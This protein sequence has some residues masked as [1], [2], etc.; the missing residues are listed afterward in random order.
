MRA[1]RL[2]IVRPIPKSTMNRL[3][4]LIDL[5]LAGPARLRAAIAGMTRE[6][7]LARPIEGRW[8]TAEVIVHLSD[9]EPVLAE[10]MKRIVALDNPSFFGADEN[11]FL[12]HLAYDARDLEEELRTIELTRSQMARI[13][14]TLPESALNRQGLR[15][16]EI[17]TTLEKILVGTIRHIDSH[18][19]FIAEKRKAMGI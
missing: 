13:L 9:F 2:R 16:G 4:E 3:P 12:K 15:N 17:P 5:Y 7:L 14:R 11:D 10:R 6:Q 18:L 8:N 1:T 19:P